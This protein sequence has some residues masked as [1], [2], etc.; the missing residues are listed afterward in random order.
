[1]HMEFDYEK[2]EE[3][4]KEIR[5]ENSRMLELFEQSLQ[6]LKPQTVKRHLSNVDFSMN[7]YLL[8]EDAL[9]VEEGVWKVDDFLGYFFIRKCMWS[10]PGT[11]KSTAASIKRFYKCMLD[12]GMIQKLDFVYLSETIKEGLPGWQAVCASYN[13]PDEDNPFDIW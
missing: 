1:M 11:I 12:N 9:S 6:D 5:E 4:C 10:T 2:Y 3:R 7:N 13:N 8:Y